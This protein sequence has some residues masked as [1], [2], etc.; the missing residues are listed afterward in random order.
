MN[1]TVIPDSQSPKLSEAGRIPSS[2]TDY[3]PS[4][5]E[6]NLISN[7][8]DTYLDLQESYIERP[9]RVAPVTV[10]YRL[11]LQVLP[12]SSNN[13][14]WD[15]RTSQWRLVETDPDAPPLDID[16]EAVTWKKCQHDVVDHI[17][18]DHPML[19]DYLNRANTRAKTNWFGS[20]DGDDK[21]GSHEGGGVL[22]MDHSHFHDFATRAYD[23]YPRN[24]KIRIDMDPPVNV[25]G[26]SIK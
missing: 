12:L 19:K 18:K 5:V 8:Q 13:G 20:I 23:A 10:N 3:P 1:K 25:S 2:P 24:I 7:S 26:S 14:R 15:G 9:P 16:L 21:Y 22:L 17:A 6:D 11:F 4:E